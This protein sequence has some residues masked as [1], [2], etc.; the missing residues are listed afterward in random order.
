MGSYRWGGAVVKRK[1]SGV[2]LRRLLLHGGEV[3]RGPQM[4]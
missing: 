3:E 4:R 2:E 1:G